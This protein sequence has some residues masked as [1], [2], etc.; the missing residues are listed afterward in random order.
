MEPGQPAAVVCPFVRVI[1][2]DV[3]FMLLGQSGN[4]SLYDTVSMTNMIIIL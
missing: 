1:G 4:G 3:F 2:P